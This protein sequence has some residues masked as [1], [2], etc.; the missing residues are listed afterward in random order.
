MGKDQIAVTITMVV[1]IG[2]MLI[3]IAFGESD[4]KCKTDIKD[5]LLKVHKRA[6]HHFD[7]W[8]AVWPSTTYSPDEYPELREKIKTELIKPCLEIIEILEKEEAKR[9]AGFTK[10]PNK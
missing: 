5:K 3:V 4:P 7:E 2:T 9:K 8:T 10:N 1:M 6:E